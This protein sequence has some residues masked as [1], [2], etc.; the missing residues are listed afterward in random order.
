M[1]GRVDENGNFD[2]DDYTYADYNPDH[3]LPLP[4]YV[5]LTKSLDLKDN[6]RD[7]IAFVS[8]LEFGNEQNKDAI[9]LLSKF[10]RGEVGGPQE[11]KIS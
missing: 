5:D 2:V 7:Y 1:K 4:E 11:Q 3:L 6:D 8:G 10:F 9:N